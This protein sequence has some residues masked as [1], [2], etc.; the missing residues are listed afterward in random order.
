M[1]PGN[2][3]S[4]MAGS[5]RLFR[6]AGITVSIHWTWL[7]VAV[8]QLQYRTDAYSQQFWKVAEYLALFGIKGLHSR[9]I[10]LTRNMKGSFAPLRKNQSTGGF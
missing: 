2:S 3:A 10:C 9:P 6:V 7:L 5:F 4:P 8:F 1:P